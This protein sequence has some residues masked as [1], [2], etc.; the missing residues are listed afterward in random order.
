MSQWIYLSTS[1]D[2]QK[3]RKFNYHTKQKIQHSMT[4]EIK[5]TNLI[6]VQ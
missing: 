2:C 6:S 4:A 3:Q 5:M 1:Y